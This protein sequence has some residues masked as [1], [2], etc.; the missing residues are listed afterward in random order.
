MPWAERKSRNLRRESQE[1]SGLVARLM[2]EGLQ[3]L[4][5][6]SLGFSRSEGSMVLQAPTNWIVHKT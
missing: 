3:V 1:L 6:K 2:V 5:V 4:R